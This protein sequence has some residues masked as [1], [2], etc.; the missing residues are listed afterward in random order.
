MTLSPEERKAIVEYRIE[1]SFSTLRELDYV[2]EGK[3]WNLAANRLYYSLYYM[4][5]A[6]LLHNHISATT[7]A[8]T[9]RMISL[10]FVQKGFLD[11]EDSRLLAEVFRMRQSGDYDDLF[12]WEED[13]ILPK[14]PGT[15]ALISK[16]QS[17]IEE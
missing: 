16:L 5:E 11:K 9:Q 15:K 13:Q 7:H 10:Q 4:C 12:D 8:G 14:I 2:V 3:F 1:R 6:L 17:L